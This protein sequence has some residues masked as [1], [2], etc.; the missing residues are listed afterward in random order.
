MVQI[1]R[2]KS[3][4]VNSLEDISRVDRSWT[5]LTQR[6]KLWHRRHRDKRVGLRVYDQ[7]ED[8]ASPLV[9]LVYGHIEIDMVLEV[10][11]S[12]SNERS[13]AFCRL[14]GSSPSPSPGGTRKNGIL[15]GL[16]VGYGAPATCR[17]RFQSS[18]CIARGF[19]M[20]QNGSS[21][22]TESQN[23]PE[24]DRIPASLLM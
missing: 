20:D 23:D 13:E 14:G 15:S 2:T 18:E 3:A 21:E 10:S 1:L 12:R 11:I 22:M 7:N 6:T 24:K 5:T 9:F 17:N 16:N 19:I 8:G 4:K